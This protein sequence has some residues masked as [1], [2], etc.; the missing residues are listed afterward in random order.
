MKKSRE[1]QEDMNEIP[2]GVT[3]TDLRLTRHPVDTPR[4]RLHRLAATSLRAAGE[5]KSA[6][7][8]DKDDMAELRELA[9]RGLE[10]LGNP[11]TR[12]EELVARFCSGLDRA[13]FAIMLLDV[14]SVVKLS[15]GLVLTL[16]QL[17]AAETK[18]RDLESCLRN[19][20][21]D[22]ENARGNV[23]QLRTLLAKFHTEA[24]KKEASEFEGLATNRRELTDDEKRVIDPDAP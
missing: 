13:I 12:G 15:E 18:V 1:D 6:A 20:D 23:T 24:A 19:A 17:E 16:L 2:K 14:D 3:R 22:V 8:L 10:L 5:V 9:R 21:R 11:T 7:E 4:A